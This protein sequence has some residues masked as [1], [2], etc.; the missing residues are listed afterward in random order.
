MQRSKDRAI[1]IDS[2]FT[3]ASRQYWRQAFMT[4]VQPMG[5]WG[6]AHAICQTGITI[7]PG[8]DYL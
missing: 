8:P 4:R 6:H 5:V 7:R 3:Q 2:A 1:D